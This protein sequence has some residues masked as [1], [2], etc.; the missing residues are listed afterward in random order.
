MIERSRQFGAEAE[1]RGLERA[2]LDA[3]FGVS[4]DY[5]AGG[6]PSAVLVADD[7]RI[8][9]WLA[10]GADSIEL[11]VEQALGGLGRT[12]G[13]P[14]GAEAPSVELDRLDGGRAGV[15]TLNDGPT[16]VLFWNPGCGFCRAMHGDVR[17]WEQERDAE[18]QA[19]VVVSSGAEEDVRED[20]FGVPV[21]LDPGWEL[22]GAFGADG[23]PMA[24]L[25][26][27]DGR[28]AGP[29]VTGAE[30]V[31]ELLGAIPER[32]LR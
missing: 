16:V 14:V 2:M 29:L 12:P 22:A 23:T 31:I 11:L 15:T 5:E 25:I 7:G 18:A 8:A 1:E 28:V 4:D 30:A 26:D 32:A 10:A 17:A 9:S 24:V 6:T 3:A 21:L 13:L 27:G 20:G 19:L